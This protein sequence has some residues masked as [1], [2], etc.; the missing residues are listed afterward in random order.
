MICF[1]VGKL[2]LDVICELEEVS[3]RDGFQYLKKFFS[4]LDFE[5]QDVFLEFCMLLRLLFELFEVSDWLLCFWE[6]Q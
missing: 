3:L 6:L 4:I 5:N 1:D 2:L